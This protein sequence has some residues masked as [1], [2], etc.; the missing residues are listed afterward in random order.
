MGLRIFQLLAGLGFVAFI[1]ASPSRAESTATP[2]K[3][4]EELVRQTMTNVF[5]GFLDC[6]ASFFVSLKNTPNVLGPYVKVAERGN[7][8]APVVADPL[9]DNGRQQLFSG[10]LVIG[11]LSLVRWHNEIMYEKTKDKL[12]GYLYWGFIAEGKA[13]DVASELNKLLPPH[14]RILKTGDSWARA[15]IRRVGDQ[16]TTFKK[17]GQSGTITPRGSVERVLLVEGS[18]DLPTPST[19]VFCSLQG[20]ISPILLKSLRPDLLDKELP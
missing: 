19:K 9:V 13:D 14:K 10:P 2:L 8:A 12:D 5:M 16:L 1:L 3:G 6:D 15:E 18:S 17:G 11:Q 7:A 20:S 4:N